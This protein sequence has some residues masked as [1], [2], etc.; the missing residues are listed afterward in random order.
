MKRIIFTAASMLLCISFFAA[1]AAAASVPS[2]GA[3][4]AVLMEAESGE[5]LYNHNGDARL[6]MASTTK[7]MTALVAIEHTKH[8]DKEVRVAEEAAG[9]EGSSIYLSAGE[10]LTMEQLL[11]ALMLESANDAAAA[12]A[13][14]VAGSVD[15]FAALMN[16]KA[17]ELGLS[18]THFTNPHGLDNEE[19]YTS[20]ADLGKLASAA[21]QNETF[22]KIVSTYKNKIPLNGSE[23]TRVLVNHNRLLQSYDGTIGVKTGF[24][25]RSGRCLVSAAERDGVTLVAVTLNDP[26]D[27]KDHKT[28][29]D[30]GFS[31]YQRYTLAEEGALTFNIP[32]TGGQKDCITATNK[33]SLSLSLPKSGGPIT[34]VLEAEQFLYAPIKKGALVG[35]TVFLRDGQE[36]GR[37]P[38]Y[39]DAAC[40]TVKLQK[41]IFQFFK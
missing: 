4:S 40:P 26:D 30:Y 25:K 10:K 33:D 1:P 12:I 13:C 35:Y 5:I 2:V 32:C 14:E 41:G 11:Y 28:M 34:T 16:E 23:G 39:A 21:M 7:I 19:H 18:N 29:L 36:I 31:M 38:M 17:E 9:I 22:K 27:W 6:P 15:D 20:A 24:T 8:L 37:L 3:Q